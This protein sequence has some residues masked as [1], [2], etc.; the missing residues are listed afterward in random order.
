MFGLT[1]R[2]NKITV[3]S[4]WVMFWYDRTYMVGIGK[5]VQT[6][7]NHWKTKTLVNK[8]KH[9]NFNE[10]SKPKVESN[11]TNTTTYEKLPSDDDKRIWIS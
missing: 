3:N 10:T 8:P 7:T 6:C 5:R 11:T 2:G 4:V 1:D 9:R